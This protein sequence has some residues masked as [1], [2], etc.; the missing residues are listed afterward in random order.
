MV[1]S[2]LLISWLFFHPVHV[3]VTSID[4]IPSKDIFS[5]FLKMYVDDFLSDFNLSGLNTD[6]ADFSVI[7][8]KAKKEMESYLDRRLTISVNSYLPKRKL[9]EM[10]VEGNELSMT[11]EYIVKKTPKVIN[12][13]NSIM[14][15]LYNDQ[16]NLVILKVGNFEEGFKL[17]PESEEQTFTIK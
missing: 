11:M 5:V 3:T 17:T 12:V 10:K 14:T 16:T 2:F 7:N 8:S 4:Y 1:K 13:K 6:N 9:L 15:G